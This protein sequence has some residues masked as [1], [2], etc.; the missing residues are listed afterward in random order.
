MG[1]FHILA[2]GNVYVPVGD[3]SSERILN[4]GLNRWAI[5]PIVAI[6][7]L[8]PKYGQEVSVT[9][10][11]TMNLRNYATKYT[12]GN[13]LY[14]EWFAGQHF[15]K[16]LALGLAGYFYQQVTGDSGAGARLGP[17]LGQVLAIGALR[18]PQRQDREAPHRR[19]SAVL[20]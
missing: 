3:Y 5:E 11:Y 12:T 14:L 10:G 19:Q 4:T 7:W 17:F 6:T 1:Q 16:W 15:T 18:H 9:L 2:L 8:Q 20:R 13:E